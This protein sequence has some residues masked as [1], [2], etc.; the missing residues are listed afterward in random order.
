VKLGGVGNKRQQNDPAPTLL[1]EVQVP[2]ARLVGVANLE[3]ERR[4]RQNCLR[5]IEQL[6][7]RLAVR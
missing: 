2:R 7:A 1:A 6:P 3:H 5:R 4:K